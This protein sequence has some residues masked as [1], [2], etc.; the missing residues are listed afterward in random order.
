MSGFCNVFSM[1]K[2]AKAGK[3]K[4]AKKR[5]KK[6]KTKKNTTH[7]SKKA[8]TNLSLDFQRECTDSLYLY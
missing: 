8:G 2:K 1:G 4:K 3:G 5:Q 6:Q 7:R